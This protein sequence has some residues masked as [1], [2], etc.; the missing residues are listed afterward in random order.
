M[1]R[2]IEANPAVAPITHHEH[3]KALNA[4]VEDMEQANSMSTLGKKL[5]LGWLSPQIATQP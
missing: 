1:T 4:V 2:M 3:M 5:R